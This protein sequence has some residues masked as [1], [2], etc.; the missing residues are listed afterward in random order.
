[1]TRAVLFLALASCAPAP[2]RTEAQA[3]PC[4]PGT[5][6]ARAVVNALAGT[7]WTERGFASIAHPAI[8]EWALTLDSPQPVLG[9]TILATV[10]DDGYNAISA[11]LSPEVSPS[12][13][14]EVKT[15]VVDP[16]A[17]ATAYAADQHYS[18]AVYAVC[19]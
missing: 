1:M 6:V 5:P 3:A 18:I 11:T 13:T 9:V 7:F 12:S 8:G 16:G 17:P 15:L 10:N 19:P 4:D 14:I 2:A